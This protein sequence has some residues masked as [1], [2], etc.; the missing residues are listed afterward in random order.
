MR[1]LLQRRVPQIVGA[2][3][4]GSWILLEFTDWTV[5][6]YS[7][8]PALTNFVVTTLLLLLPTVAV[9]A[10]RHGAPG[11]DRWTKTDAAVIG[12]NMVAACG[13]LLMAFSGQELGAVTTVRLLEDD[14]GN[15][16]ERVIPKAAFRRDLIVWD[17]DNESDDPDLDW[18]R[19]GLW[20]GIV[21][22]LS[23]D[24]FVTPV[25]IYEPRVRQP[26]A[27]AGFE[28][29]YG[30]P[31]ALKRQL[32]EARGVGHFLEGE[33]LVRDGDTLVVRTRLY[34]TRNAHEVA[35]HTYRGTDPLEIVDRLSVDVRRDLGI[36]EWQIEESVD[37]PA[38]ELLTQS[39]EAFRALSGYRIPMYRI[40]LAEARGAAEAAIEIDPSFAAAYGAS[41][42]AALLQG[43]QA[44]ARD[45]IAEALRYAYRLPERSRLLLQMLD[46]MLFRIDP[47]GAL[48]TGNYWTELYPQDPLARLLL[49]ET[50]GMQGNVDGQITQYQALLS[51]DSTDVQS[52]EAIAGA[53]RGKQE[54][55][56]ALVYYARLTDLQPTDVQTRLDIAATQISLLEVDEAREEL[57][58]ARIAAPD[59]P[60][61]L[62]RLARL[63]MQQG[64][65][66]DAARRLEEMPELVR[67]PQE[68]DLVAGV[69]ETYFYNLGQY[70]GLLEAHGRRLEAIG[71]YLPPIAA[72]QAVLSSEALIYSADWGREATALVQIDSLRASV[73]EPW[74]LLLDVPAVQ[75]HLARGDIESARES[76]SALRALSE[77]FG[78]APLRAII[79]WVEGRIAELEDGD[80]TRALQSYEAARGLMPQ[81]SRYRAWLAICLTSLERWKE[82]EGEAAWLL[83]RFPGSAMVRLIAAW[84][85]SA[86]GRTADTIAELEIALD[87]WSTADPD[88]EPAREARALLE[89]LRAAG[90][91]ESGTRANP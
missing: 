77:A 66:E 32:A 41:A 64:L 53:F 42:S 36:P 82:A 51:M 80:C 58:R 52:L 88:Y 57:N 20:M 37:L 61:V 47:A 76:L 60:D 56:S 68:R 1:K 38:A 39:P 26:L 81:S 59:D 29:P 24:L 21:Q 78:T 14:D 70:G 45:G 31:L 89:E 91:A 83:E 18:L 67:T 7:L 11:E 71:E 75:I 63:D 34:E 13:I 44:A 86:R 90:H 17:F 15:S 74:S 6:Q 10:W 48:Q 62:N 35:A 12:F 40:E 28:L 4:A 2:Y 50:Y 25:D 72:V 30:V 65:Y 9:L 22:D 49:A 43:D 84:H 55:D 16:V 73:E 46:R 19:S 23:Q 54:Y 27:E 8:S 3:F 5:S 85:Y 33:L 79:P 69:A 87:Y